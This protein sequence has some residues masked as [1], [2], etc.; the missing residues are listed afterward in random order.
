MGK[1]GGEVAPAVYISYE[2]QKPGS[3]RRRL[4][5]ILEEGSEKMEVLVLPKRIL[6]FVPV[7]LSFLSY[8]LLYRHVV[9]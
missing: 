3:N 8:F 7:V 5:T 4:E 6:F 1:W 2:K 9:A